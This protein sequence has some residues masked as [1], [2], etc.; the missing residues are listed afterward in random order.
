ML[1]LFGFPH[2]EKL[3]KDRSRLC[4]RMIIRK[5]MFT[6]CFV[7]TMVWGYPIQNKFE[8]PCHGNIGC[9]TN[10]PPSTL[11]IQ[12]LRKKRKRGVSAADLL[13]CGVEQPV[14]VDTRPRRQRDHVRGRSLRV[15][16]AAPHPHHLRRKP[17]L[18]IPKN[19]DCRDPFPFPPAAYPAPSPPSLS[20]L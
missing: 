6:Q 14:R 5:R 8:L 19:N 9:I 13:P 11:E 18:L 7:F 12:T 15:L 20:P 16:Q 3:W 4:V 17:E 1:C 2:V 10:D